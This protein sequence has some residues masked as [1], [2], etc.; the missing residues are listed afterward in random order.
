MPLTICVTGG[1]GFIGSHVADAL[2][3][4]GHRVLIVDDLSGGRKENVPKDAELA[5]LDVRSEKAGEFLKDRKV[6]ILIHHAAQMDVRRSVE[7]P[8]FDA[9]VNILGLLNLLEAGRRGSL[10]QVVFAS[11]GG[12]I[13]GEQDEYPADE[14]HPARP[15]S[16]YGVAKLASERYLFYYHC[17]YG[18][19][20]TCLRYANVYGPRQNPHGEAGVV[21]IFSR[22]LLD[23]EPATINGDGLQTRDYVYVDDV[24]RANTAVVDR[25]GFD[26][27]NVGTGVETDV[28]AL[29]DTI[30]EAAEY[31]TA[32][33]HGPGMPGEQRRSCISSERLLEEM[34]VA[35]DTPLEVGI[36]ATVESFRK[37]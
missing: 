30:A 25:P 12:A 36:P 33:N 9:D 29:F 34:S 19:D 5:V 20:A 24:V 28:N 3:K 7:D 6:E 23:G 31:D 14:E 10:R 18:I 1:A 17:Q 4:A 27:F 21:A 15:L 2:V 32:P 11:T 22:K 37:R 8:R 26:V 16:P 35:I 13:Y